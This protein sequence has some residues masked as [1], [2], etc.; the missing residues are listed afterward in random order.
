M[1][2]LKTYISILKKVKNRPTKYF[3]YLVLIIVGLFLQ[4]YMHNY[5]I[6]YIMMFFLVGVAGASSIFG[7]INL[8]YIEAR[9]LSNERFFA[10]MDSFYTL[11]ISN[12][13]QNSAYSISLSSNSQTHT[14]TS[15]EPNQSKTLQFKAKFMQRGLVDVPPIVVS[16]FFPLPHEIK[17][18]NIDLKR[19]LFVYAQPKGVSLFQNYNRSSAPSGE[20]ED[21]HEIAD[22]EQGESLSYIHWPS[23]AK[24]D[25]LKSKRFIYE[26]PKRKL[27]FSYDALKGDKEQRVSQLTLWVLECE[28]HNLEFSLELQSKKYNSKEQSIDELLQI[29]AQY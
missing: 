4:A 26:E 8:Y 22:F 6:V 10:T 25:T 14:I 12:H 1:K 19:S 7:I 21:F 5:N 18:K 27:H 3:F 17:Y 11:S 23:L 20:I 2:S 13:S 16:S 28:K 24:S 15:I 9:L 29:I